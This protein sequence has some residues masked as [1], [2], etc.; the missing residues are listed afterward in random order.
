MALFKDQPSIGLGQNATP[1]WHL[2]E[3]STAS[4]KV[5]LEGSARIDGHFD[6]EITAND[7]VISA[8]PP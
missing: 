3:G 8:R 2:P 6:G 5:N 7:T 1:E 4:G